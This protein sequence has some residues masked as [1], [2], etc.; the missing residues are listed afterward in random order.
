MASRER[1]EEK[2]VS[3]TRRSFVIQDFNFF[4]SVTFFSVEKQLLYDKK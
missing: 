3:G 1:K 4:I 2:E